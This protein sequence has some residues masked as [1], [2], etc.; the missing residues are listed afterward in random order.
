M[1]DD[2]V[3]VDGA[4]VFLNSLPVPGRIGLASIAFFFFVR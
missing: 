1:N 4:R 3:S 2:T